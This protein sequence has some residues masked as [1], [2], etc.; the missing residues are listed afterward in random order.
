MNN[1]KNWDIF[2]KIVD[3]FGDIGVCW[4]LAK[5]LHQAHHV[6][7]KLFVDDLSAAA[8]LLTDIVDIPEQQLQGVT[9]I[10]WD[11]DTSFNVAADVVIETFAC[12][13]P[14]A[15]LSLMSKQTVWV[16]VDYLSAE[17]WVPS[18]HGLHGKHRETAF[19][20]HFYFPGFT[21]KTG[22][23]LR[24]QDLL[25]NRNTF[26]ASESLQQAFW[27]SLLIAKHA[28]DLTISLFHYRQAPVD[29]LLQ[30]L[31]GGQQ[32]VIVLMPLN[33]H[34][35]TSVLGYTDLTVGDCITVGALT[36]HVLPFLSQDDYDRLL[37]VC[38]INFVRGEDSWVR[39]IFAGKPFIWQPYWQQDN[40]HLLKLNAFLSS[41]YRYTTLQPTLV[42]LHEAWSTERFHAEAWQ[43]Y[44][45]NLSALTVY[46]QQQSQM[47]AKQADL[48]SKLLSFCA[49]LV[50]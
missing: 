49:D 27:R 46:T 4:R 20:R 1:Q 6:D 48:A 2:C 24:E 7:I 15:Y 37:W 11:A 23:L 9:V 50:N 38:D 33:Q 28:S 29:A 44:L 17:S 16:N 13:L 39:A 8:N 36:L 26:Q 30:S 42:R 12:G 18:F 34:M 3:N 43:H 45:K 47:L 5:Q 35:P 19:T 10:R 32:S 25:A 40:A 14:A 22:G 21:D 31:A 41:F